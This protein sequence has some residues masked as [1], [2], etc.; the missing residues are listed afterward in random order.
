MSDFLAVGNDIKNWMEI[1]V[2]YLNNQSA[3]EIDERLSALEQQLAQL[4][5]L[6]RRLAFSVITHAGGKDS[7]QANDWIRQHMNL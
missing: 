6:L 3:A 5:E 7:K 1:I 2:D 4:P